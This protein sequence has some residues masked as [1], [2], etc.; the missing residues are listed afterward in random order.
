[1]QC[2]GN[3]EVVVKVGSGSGFAIELEQPFCHVIY[4]VVEE[5]LDPAHMEN[6]LR[7]MKAERTTKRI[8]FNPSFASAG[9]TLFVYVPKLP[10][11]GV[12]VTSSLALRFDIDLSEG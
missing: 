4:L 7:A 6:I 8:T 10:E 5:T 9:K 1:M 2:L 12:P 3:S 11:P